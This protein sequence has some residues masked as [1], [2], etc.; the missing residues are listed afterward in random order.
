M[1][2]F[3]VNFWFHLSFLT[4]WFSWRE[5]I[6]ELLITRMLWASQLY[7]S[8]WFLKRYLLD[9]LLLETANRLIK[10]DVKVVWTKTPFR[11]LCRTY[12]L[13]GKVAKLLNEYYLH[14]FESFWIS[15]NLSKYLLCMSVNLSNLLFLNLF[16][17]LFRIPFSV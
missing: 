2:N 14:L 16:E 11:E 13:S 3:Y 5:R 8:F 17:Y 1:K 10:V 12:S 7:F 6:F 9:L 15:E 4:L